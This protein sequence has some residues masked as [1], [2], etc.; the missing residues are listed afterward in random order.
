MN[1]KYERIVGLPHKQSS[2]RKHM[3]L[4]DRA[5]QFAPFAALLFADTHHAL[6]KY[7]VLF[8]ES[9]AKATESARQS[10]LLNELEEGL[11]RIDDFH[12]HVLCM[13]NRT[14]WVDGGVLIDGAVVDACFFGELEDHVGVLAAAVGNLN[15]P[16][17]VVIILE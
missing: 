16:L 10:V 3:S 5:A 14:R 17:R 2:T 15:R 6:I 8:E 9:A 7:L 4:H 12:S 13:L 11:F 1:E